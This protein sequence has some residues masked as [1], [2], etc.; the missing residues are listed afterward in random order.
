MTQ[1]TRDNGRHGD[2]AAAAPD[3]ADQVTEPGYGPLKIK[4]QLVT[5]QLL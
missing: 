5:V 4:R 2:W 3:R 1:R